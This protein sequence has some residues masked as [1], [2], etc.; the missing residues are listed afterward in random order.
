MSQQNESLDERLNKL[1]RS[2]NFW[3]KLALGQLLILA[4]VIVAGVGTLSLMAI[5][6]RQAEMVAREEALRA[7]EAAD[8]VLR[9]G[10][11]ATRQAEAERRAR[12][13]DKK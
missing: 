11:E 4:M 1:Q 6:A 9:Q 3:K 10:E 5:R 7:R 12:E 2:R 13:K 8:Q